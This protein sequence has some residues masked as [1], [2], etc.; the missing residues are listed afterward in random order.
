MA[1]TLGDMKAR[2]ATE[3]ARSD[4]TTQIA[5]AI[6]DAILICQ[7]YRFTFSEGISG[8]ALTFDTQLGTNYYPL[9]GPGMYQIDYMECVPKNQVTPLVRISRKHPEL[10]RL[11][12][13]V[14]GTPNLFAVE[15]ERIVLVPQPDAIYTVIVHG[16][17]KIGAPATDVE[18]GNRWMLDGERLIR[19]L[20]KRELARDVTRN[21]KMQAAMN[22][23]F[24]AEGM[25]MISEHDRLNFYQG[26]HFTTEDI[27]GQQEIIAPK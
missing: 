27:K 4:L 12:L 25:Q 20:A 21:E 10:V 22:A 16:H 2:I 8:E 6:N 7:K 17:I 1:N 3:L 15:S 19:L 23:A 11:K 5:S 26:M 9:P 24:I 13:L 14:V 18:A